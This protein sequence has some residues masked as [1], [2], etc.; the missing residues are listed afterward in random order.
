MAIKLLFSTCICAF[1]GWLTNFLAIK[2]LFHP[3]KPVSVCGL[4]L[5][6]I[7][8]KRQKALAANLATAI[9]DELFSHE[10]IQNAMHTPEFTARVKEKLLTGFTDFLAHR[11]GE[12]HPMASMFLT[13]ELIDNIAKLLESELE[14]I[15]PALLETAAQEMEN[16]LDLT[17]LIQEK[18]ENLS[19]PKL[20]KLL[21]GIMSREFRFVEIVGAVLGAII[22]LSQGLMFFFV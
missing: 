3:H 9:E 16:S 14:R 18:I 7:F 15:V 17:A 5:H 21:M 20:E 4:K 8:P 19:I 13:P 11:L 6:G 22:G 2:M 10:D 1:I 12:V